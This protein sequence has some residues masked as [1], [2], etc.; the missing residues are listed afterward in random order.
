MVSQNAMVSIPAGLAAGLGGLWATKHATSRAVRAWSPSEHQHERTG[1]LA[2]KRF[3]QGRRLTVIFHG[4]GATADYF[5]R[6]YDGLGDQ[7]RVA[8]PDLLGF[9]GSLDENRSSFGL[10][11][12]LD[13][14]DASLLA[15]APSEEVVIIAHF[16]GLGAGHGLGAAPSRTRRRPGV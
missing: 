10:K 14:L 3:G 6:S 5:G 12:H 9:G 4:L 8:I 2:V 15:D 16:D 1:P 13:A 7:Q 11:D